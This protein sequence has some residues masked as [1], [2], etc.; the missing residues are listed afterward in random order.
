MI[1][2]PLSRS[3]GLLDGDAATAVARHRRREGSG[4]QVRRT[5]IAVEEP[6][7]GASVE[8][9]AR[10]EPGR[11]GVV[12]QNVDTADLRDEMRDVGGIAQIRGNESRLSARF[13]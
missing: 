13:L 7:I 2:Y 10:P 1:V 4:Q 9:A 3:A 12:D 11:A 8:F 5:D 6:V